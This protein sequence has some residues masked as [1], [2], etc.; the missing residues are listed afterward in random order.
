MKTLKLL[1]G[2]IG[3]N[4]DDLKFGNDFSDMTPK[5]QITEQKKK[6]KDKLEV[7]QLKTFMHQILL[8]E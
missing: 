2:N 7:S 4:I 8:T 5:A 3:E 6:K 1:E